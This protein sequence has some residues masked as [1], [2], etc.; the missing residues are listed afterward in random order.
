M[1]LRCVAEGSAIA[2]RQAASDCVASRKVCSR[3]SPNCAGSG[4]F[5]D[6]DSATWQQPID[7]LG[8]AVGGE[9]DE[10]AVRGSV[11]GE[12]VPVG[13]WAEDGFIIGWGIAVDQQQLRTAIQG[14]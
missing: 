2:Y 9:D 13:R 8:R 7:R 10:V 11:G 3:S 5:P 14:S 1:T 6:L 4:P 12:N